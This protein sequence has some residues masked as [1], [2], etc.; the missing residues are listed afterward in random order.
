ML[1]KII[2]I[3]NDN[4]IQCDTLEE[5]VKTLI[6]GNFYN[7]TPS[8]KIE[9]MRIKALANCI[10]NKK[11]VVQG[12][13][14]NA[15]ESIQDKFIIQDEITY[16]LSL[17]TTNNILLLE[18]KDSDIFTKDLNKEN[19]KDNYIIVNKFANVLLKK[20]IMKD[21]KS[22]QVQTLNEN[23][24]KLEDEEISIE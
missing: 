5:V 9:K 24:I 13:S 21:K 10:N 1:K 3:E 20:Y 22:K 14:I 16:I 7:M 23:G 11:K 12:A 17:L 4:T 8:Q 6:D 18:R 2:L 19:L 15:E